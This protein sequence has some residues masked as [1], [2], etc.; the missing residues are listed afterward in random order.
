M[1]NTAQL[2]IFHPYSIDGL[3]RLGN[4][5]DGGYIVHGP[6]LKDIDMLV[7]YGVGYNV[8]FEKDFNIKTKAP[9]LAFDPTMK[10]P[11][12]F[13]DK[14]RQGSYLST[15]KQLRWLLKWMKEEKRLPD[16]RIKFVEEGISETDNA[17]Y[18]TFSTH[19]DEYQLSDKKLMLKIDVDGAEYP[20]FKDADIYKRL[21][22]VVQL[23]IEFHDL[24]KY[25]H[26]VIET[27]ENLATS[28]TLIHIHGNNYGEPFSYEGK[29]IPRVIEATLIHNSY[30][31][32][33]TLSTAEYPIH[34]LDSPCDKRKADLPL[35]F[36]R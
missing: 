22:N 5:F 35:A 9:V 30:L 8:E 18:K 21:D 25:I 29:S 33:K 6:S 2:G 20:V 4:K 7:T 28:H 13:R 19:I 32:E 23:I 17:S 10:D 15:V 11:R 31:P 36:F 12:V 16:H 34:E 27:I 1:K 14:I 26:Q 3:I 24:D